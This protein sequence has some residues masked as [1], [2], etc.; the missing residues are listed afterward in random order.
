M[1][2]TNTPHQIG[3]AIKARRRALNMSQAQLA[4]SAKVSRK[5]I[6]NLESG[7]PTAE[8]GLLLSVC[9]ALGLSMVLT[10]RAG[11]VAPPVSPLD[12]V[13]ARHVDRP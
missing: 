10:E 6:S 7:K 5:W 11:G 12:D 4:G 3:A 1:A 13:L 8:I 2:S 9:D